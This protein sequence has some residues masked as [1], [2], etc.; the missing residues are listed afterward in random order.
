MR[1]LYSMLFTLVLLALV[2]Y[3]T[4]QVISL[5]REVATLKKEIV[6]AKSGHGKSSGDMS[7]TVK[8]QKHIDLAKQ[9]ALKGDFKRADKELNRGLEIL[10]QAG[11]DT[12][13]PY[14]DKLDKAE[15]A[16]T[17]TRGLIQRLWGNT[18]KASKEGKGG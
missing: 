9:Y 3:N 15:R 1:R 11:R 14:T 17:E 2:V 13:E 5:K 6:A 12:T 8:A 7:A 16:L 4:G 10:Q 18:D